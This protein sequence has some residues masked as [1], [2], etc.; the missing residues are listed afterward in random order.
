VCSGSRR[1][2]DADVACVTAG[3]VAAVCCLTRSPITGRELH[4]CV[5]AERCIASDGGL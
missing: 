3:Q 2:T 5:L 1:W 4:A